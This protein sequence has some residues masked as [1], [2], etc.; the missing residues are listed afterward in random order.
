VPAYNLRVIRDGHLLTGGPDFEVPSGGRFA[1]AAVM[2]FR[3]R[4]LVQAQ[5]AETGELAVLEALRLLAKQ[6][7]LQVGHALKIERL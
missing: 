2:A 6:E 7:R 5:E 4:A 1:V 3:C